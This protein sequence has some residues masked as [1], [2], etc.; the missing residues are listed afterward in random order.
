MSEFLTNIPVKYPEYGVIT[1]QTLKQYTVRSM[2]VQD[3]E[4][5]K[6]SYTT[7]NQFV[8]HLNKMIFGCC[9]AKPDGVTDYDSFLKST[10]V[11]DRDALLY[12][13]YQISYKD[14]NNYETQCFACE[15]KFEISIDISKAFSMTAWKEDGVPLPLKDREVK[16]TLPV[17]DNIIA[18]IRQPTLLD[19]DDLVK[20]MLFQSKKNL[21]MGVELLVVHHF[22]LENSA[23]KNSFEEVRERDNIFSIFQALPSKDRKAINKAYL[24]NFGKY[25]VELKIITR[26]P[27]CGE[28]VTTYIDLVRQFFRALYE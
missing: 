25:G 7:P 14:V 6:G 28:E 13:I 16:I 8:Q 12:G 18:V 20:D 15:R 22:E 9:V 11:R 2:N 4:N 21:D 3:E 26:C 19:E 17:S 27:Q 10:T 5:L 1:P 24:E 23:A